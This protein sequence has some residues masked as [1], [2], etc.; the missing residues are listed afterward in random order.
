MAHYVS[1]LD[2]RTSTTP[3]EWLKTCSEIGTLVNEWANRGDIVVY[4]GSDAGAGHTACYIKS[5]AEMEI[6]IPVAFGSFATPEIVGDFT[7]RETHYE[8]A[9]ATGVIYHESLHAR[10]SE[11]E[12]TALES[13]GEKVFRTFA[14][15]D[16]SR[17]ERY[18]VLN[19]PQN[20]LFLRS[21]AL[22]L[23]LRE[24]D[25]K[26]NDLSSIR[27]SAVLCLLSL[28][29]V[30]AGVLRF[31]D[32]RRT[33][34]KVMEVLG[35]ENFDK[36]R[37]IWVEF[38]TLTTADV[39][40]AGELAKA[41][42]DLL[43]ELDPEP[44][45]FGCE[46][47]GG[48][49]GDPDDDS[50]TK[51]KGKGKGKGSNKDLL[52]AMEQDADD[53]ATSNADDLYEQQI[54]QE[55]QDKLNEKQLRQSQIQKAKNQATKTFSSSTGPGVSG[56]SSTL[57]EVRTPS[58]NERA[59]AV[60]IAQMLEKAKYRERSITDV[61]SVLPQGRL[62]TRIAIQNLALKAKGVRQEVPAWERTIRKHTDDPT[63][64]IGIMV[65]VSGSMGG[66]MD[67]M[68][69]TAWVLSE[70]GRRVQAKTA[71]VYFGSGVFPTL[72]VGQ[73]LDKVSVY[74]APDGT[75]K[76]DEG[77]QALDGHLGL[78]YSS[79][80]RL[81]VIVSDGQYTPYETTNA[82]K[83]LEMCKQNGVAVLWV[84][85]DGCY[86]QGAKSIVGNNGVVLDQMKVSEIAMA[87]G[88]SAT[89]ALT[90]ISVGG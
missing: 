58:G 37:A 13:M 49:S 77:W 45:D 30:D 2:T 39:V 18:G 4:A 3:K 86:S 54:S 17:I 69:T 6:N 88:K 71:M 65:D 5:V 66:A 44:D 51:G 57:K 34:E 59:S 61:R 33:Y 68:A 20:T 83:A 56:S 25:E 67:A 47:P 14:L 64:S 11:W 84:V 42:N 8:W 78:T 41:W 80:V 15:L 89:D 31:S 48:E 73:K 26:I 19:L 35:K 24:V 40:R 9:S 7:K 21:S 75:E 62:K 63:L 55:Q 70:S 22:E 52:D 82:K 38:Q 43:D 81:L 72:K 36:F 90:K 23:A 76:F 46:F 10:F 1:R 16:E 29:R 85:P 32:V 87:I 79:G 60:K 53:T 74:T 50:E 28:A 12:Q 27:L